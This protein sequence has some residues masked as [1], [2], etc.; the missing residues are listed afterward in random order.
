MRKAFERSLVKC[1]MQENKG[2]ILN[3]ETFVRFSKLCKITNIM[4]K[5][6]LLFCANYEYSKWIYF[7]RD[8][9]LY[10]H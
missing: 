4:M 6:Y 7:F 1:Y 3:T 9:F 2:W 10:M 5:L 8:N